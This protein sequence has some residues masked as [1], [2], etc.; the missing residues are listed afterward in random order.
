MKTVANGE[1]PNTK[2]CSD[3]LALLLTLAQR[4]TKPVIWRGEC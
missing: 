3:G 1:G 2:R 4:R